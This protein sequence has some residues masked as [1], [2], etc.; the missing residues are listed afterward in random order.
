MNYYYYY[1]SYSSTPYNNFTNL[2]VLNII[3]VTA[4]HPNAAVHA[5]VA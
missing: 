3:V 5:T 1:S 2:G 4:A